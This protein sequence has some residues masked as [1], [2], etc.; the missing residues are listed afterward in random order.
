MRSKVHRETGEGEEKMQEEMRKAV[1]DRYGHIAAQEGRC[2]LPSASYCGGGNTV[3]DISRAVGYRPEDL[4]AVP[5]GSNLGLGCGN[6]VALAS[7]RE[8]ETVIDLG[9]GAG[10]DCFLA[11][12][13]VGKT[14]G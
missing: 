12:G 6:P 1:R 5:E 13:R 4:L 11:A 7:L 14:G 3:E 8:G 2:C 9:A 10:F